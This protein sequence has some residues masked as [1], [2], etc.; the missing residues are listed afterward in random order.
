[1][2]VIKKTLF[3]GNILGKPRH[4]NM[5]LDMEENIHIHYRD[6]RIELSRGEFEDIV[7]TFSKQSQELLAVIEEKKYQDGNLPNANQ[8]DVRVWTES[9]L[10]HDVKYHPQRF[11]LE[12]CGD[13]YHFHYRNYK[14]LI[15]SADF[16]QIAL[17][18]EGHRLEST[19]RY[20]GIEVDDA[21]EISE[22]TEI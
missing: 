15:D 10:K 12:D 4:R 13:G 14:L 16:H 3:R 20:L 8:D 11:S 1:M 22:Q 6:L 19:V 2:G 7:A 9:R 17:C 21:L 5:F 18:T